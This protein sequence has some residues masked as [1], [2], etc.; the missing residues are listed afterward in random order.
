[1]KKK[2]DEQVAQKKL[3]NIRSYTV[4]HAG[5]D[6]SVETNSTDKHKIQAE[7]VGWGL[8]VIKTEAYQENKRRNKRN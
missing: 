5:S 6:H 3:I 2:L 1:M 8:V 4:I 7:W